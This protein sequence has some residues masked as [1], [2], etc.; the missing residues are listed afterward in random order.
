MERLVDLLELRLVR[1]EVR[2]ALV[3][4]DALA[5]EVEREPG[6][7]VGVHLEA[8]HHVLLAEAELLEDRAVRQELDE[9]AVALVRVLALAALLA[10]QLALLE[11]RLGKLAVAHGADVE[12]VRERVDGLGAHAVHAHGELEALGVELAAGVQLAHAVHDLA[13]RDAAP[14]VAHAA[15]AAVPVELDLH[16]PPVAHDELVDRVVDDLLQQH[17]DAVVVVA[18][19]A[20]PADVHPEAQPD[21]LHRA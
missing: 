4:H 16:A 7:Q 15:R 19:V 10:L 17:V 8:P 12:P 20:G 13:E 11:Q 5:V 2:E 9:R 3:A 1:D 6:V 18:A 14:V 21:M